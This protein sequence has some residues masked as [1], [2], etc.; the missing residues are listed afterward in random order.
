MEFKSDDNTFLSI[1]AQ[2]TENWNAESIFEDLNCASCFFEQGTVGYSPDSNGVSFNGLELKTHKWEV[3]PLKVK[4]VHS[5]FFENEE[6]FPPG[7]IRFDNALLMKNIE[8]E[9]KSLKEIKLH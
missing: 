3:T 2:E 6:I 1:K 8:H 4:E 7:S 9:W 5:S